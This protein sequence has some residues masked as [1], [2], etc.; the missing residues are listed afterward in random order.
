MGWLKKVIYDEILDL[1]H[2][3]TR[4]DTLNI[5]MRIKKG[6]LSIFRPH[7]SISKGFSLVEMLIY[8]GLLTALVGVL[9][10]VFATIVD[11]QLRSEASS[12]ID[13]DGRYI[14]SK[15]LYDMKSANSIT[16]PS[17]AGSSGSTLQMLVNNITYTYS[18][19]GSG[20]LQLVNNYGTSVLNGYD[21]SVSGLSFQRLGAGD[22]NDTIRVSFT[23]T[24]R[25][26]SHG[27]AESRS[28]QTTLSRDYKK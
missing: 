23:L 19:D 12:S 18:L 25:T 21:T 11:V 20:N 6:F 14:I 22:S 17:S 13:Q 1:L 10:M 8:M 16:T 9:S 2:L 3:K 5:V 27:A 24:S 26:I 28:F 15:L 7:F 4:T